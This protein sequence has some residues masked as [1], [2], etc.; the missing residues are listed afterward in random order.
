VNVFF[1]SYLFHSSEW[2]KN[3][4]A[5][6]QYDDDEKNIVVAID[7]ESFYFGQHFIIISHVQGHTKHRNWRRK[8]NPPT[9][10]D[11]RLNQ[12][13]NFTISM[14]THTN[15][16]QVKL[17]FFNNFCCTRRTNWLT[18]QKRLSRVSEW[19]ISEKQ[20]HKVTRENQHLLEC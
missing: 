1:H 10:D 20:S 6:I 12:L 8:K 9:A 19:V 13:V 16:T 14:P 11:W 2:W 17:V 15:R 5:K 18:F 7:T 3:L 4:E